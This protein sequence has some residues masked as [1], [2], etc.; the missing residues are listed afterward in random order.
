MVQ[1]TFFG[2][3]L[4]RVNGAGGPACTILP[5]AKSLLT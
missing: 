5:Q 2:D 4:V 3:D 1:F